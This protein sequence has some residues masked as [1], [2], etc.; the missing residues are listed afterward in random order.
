MRELPQAPQRWVE[1]REQAQR[2][3]I[4][5][6]FSG[7]TPGG[8]NDKNALSND[9]INTLIERMKTA[10]ITP[11]NLQTYLTE[12][13]ITATPGEVATASAG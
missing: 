10:P 9:Q 8:T 7:G 4:I 5:E 11:A 13:N 2:S 3:E 1:R 6:R 12:Q